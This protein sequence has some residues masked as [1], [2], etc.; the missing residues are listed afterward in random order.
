MKF[1]KYNLVA[2][3]YPAVLCSLPILVLNYFLLESYLGNFFTTVEGYKL[4]GGVTLSVV[5]VYFFAHVGR[6]VG[7]EVFEKIHFRD[8]VD[9][10][11][12]RVFMHSDKTYTSEQKAILYS[13]V[14]SEFGITLCTIQ[15]EIDN[16]ERA[17]RLIVDCALL[18]RG[19]VKDGRLLLQHNIEYGFARNLLGGATVAVFISVVNLLLFGYFV[20]EP[21]AYY[22]SLTLAFMYMLVMMVGRRVIDRYG[23]RY[24][25]IL[26]Q[27]YLLM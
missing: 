13:K 15:E 24:A 22:L 14:S 21:V 3:V 16:E 5:L 1:N 17:R 10:P 12:T 4:A 11:T 2:R 7:K 25:K 6:F 8:E 23:Y 18:I 26:I 27:E 9:M 19:R 20:P